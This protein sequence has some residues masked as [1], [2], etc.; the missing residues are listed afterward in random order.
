M[1]NK[2]KSI[3]LSFL[4]TVVLLV[5]TCGTA[6]A[7]VSYQTGTNTEDIKTIQ[8]KQEKSHDMLIRIDENVKQL[9]KE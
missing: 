2:P 9:M 8:D 6:W 5:F 7:V 4:L 1:P 3:S